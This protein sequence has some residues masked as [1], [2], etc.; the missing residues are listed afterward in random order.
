MNKETFELDR[1]AAEPMEQ[2]AERCQAGTKKIYN[3]E[4]QKE[5]ELKE[6]LTLMTDEW[7]DEWV[8]VQTV[9]DLRD[10]LVEITKGGK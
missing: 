3:A 1:N 8:C 2:G 7:L 6:A 4:A 5:I 10:A 9:M